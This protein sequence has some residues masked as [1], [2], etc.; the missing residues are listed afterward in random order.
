[1]NPLHAFADDTARPSRDDVLLTPPRSGAAAPGAGRAPLAISWSEAVSGAD[2]PFGIDGERLYG[3]Q[4]VLG[5]FERDPGRL[6]DPAEPRQ[7]V[8][9]DRAG[10]AAV[11][12]V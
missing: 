9:R 5:G 1:M 12:R 6:T 11:R 8:E 10:P 3:W 4:L 2:G 7:P